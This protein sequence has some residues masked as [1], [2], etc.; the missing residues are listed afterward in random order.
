MPGFGIC[1]GVF[2]CVISFAAFSEQSLCGDAVL[3]LLIE[4][5]LLN[6]HFVQYDCAKRERDFMRARRMVRLLT[7]GITAILLAVPAGGCVAEGENAFQ[8]APQKF[9]FSLNKLP[10]NGS[11]FS[12]VISD[13]DERTISGNFSVQ[14][15]Q[16]LRAIM[17]E[18]QKF[19]LTA[20]AAGAKAPIT[21]RFMDRQEPAF[22]LDVEKLGNQSRLFLTLKSEIGRMT[23]DAGKVDRSTRREEGFFFELVTSLDSVLPKLPPQPSK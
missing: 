15:L 4:G 18:A 17:T 8:P 7:L 9:S 10:E 16:I 21:T 14:Q 13:G 19:A 11:R 20:E 23:A 5:D 2:R 6:D 3:D 12:L 1:P 22:R